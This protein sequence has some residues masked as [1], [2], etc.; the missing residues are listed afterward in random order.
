MKTESFVKSEGSEERANL[1]KVTLQRVD[2]KASTYQIDFC[3]RITN[4]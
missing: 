3:I 2:D 1:I 4:F